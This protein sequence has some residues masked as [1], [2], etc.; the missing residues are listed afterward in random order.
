[1]ASNSTFHTII[2]DP[3][4]AHRIITNN[5]A[6]RLNQTIHELPSSLRKQCKESN[7]DLQPT[8]SLALHNIVAATVHYIR[9]KDIIPIIRAC[10]QIIVIYSLTHDKYEWIGSEAH[11]AIEDLTAKI[12]TLLLFG[13][14][15][16]APGSSEGA[17]KDDSV[18]AVMVFKNKSMLY[19][20]VS[21]IVARILELGR[22]LNLGEKDFV[23][24]RPMG[25]GQV[26]KVR[27][28]A[29]MLEGRKY[30][31]VGEA[32]ALVVHCSWR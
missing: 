13:T 4:L 32:V 25:Q 21:T 15:V 31:V 22:S 5:V 8:F 2:T 23:S 18:D 20:H 12:G 6:A 28:M 3:D 16:P 1:M 17:M 24:F 26:E 9:D 11:R 19:A 29:K 30:D 14:D 7:E 10:M 27:V